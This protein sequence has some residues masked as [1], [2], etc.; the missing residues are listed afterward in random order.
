MKGLIPSRRVRTR[1]RC[2]RNGHSL[3]SVAGYVC[4]E[5]L[6]TSAG[7]WL[8]VGSPLDDRVDA[9]MVLGG[10]ASTRPFVAAAIIRAGL[11]SQVLIPRTAE[12]DEG[13]DPH[14]PAAP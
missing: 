10:D 3:R 14:G 12:P 8:N 1:I 11:A 5:S 2:R 9:V 6:L 7:Q 4:R 13:G